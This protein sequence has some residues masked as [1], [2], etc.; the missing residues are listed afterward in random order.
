M[1]FEKQ[2]NKYDGKILDDGDTIKQYEID[3]ADE[4]EKFKATL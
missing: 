2:T 3:H 4:I 1:T